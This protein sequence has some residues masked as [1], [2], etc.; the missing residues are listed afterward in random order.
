MTQDSNTPLNEPNF[1]SQWFQN[2][3]ENWQQWLDELRDRPNLRCLEIGCFEGQATRWLLENILTDS[4]SHIDCVDLFQ[5][6]HHVNDHDYRSYHKTFRHNTA[7]WRDRVTEYK[8]SSHIEL[9]KLQGPYDMIYIDGW[10]TAYAALSDAVMSWPLLAVGG[11]MIFD[12]YLWS[13]PGFDTKANKPNWFKR[14]YYSHVLGKKWRDY[15]W[16]E[17]IKSV[18]TETPK[19]G[20]DSFLAVIDGQYSMVHRH[21]QLAIQKT[22]EVW[23]D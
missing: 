12:D 19:L 8:G 5:D 17:V 4:G 23:L 22:Q 16:D 13:P 20:I 3:I 18:A 14:N 11:I 6:N 9:R 15:L 2:N 1:S 7:P 10:H 21:H